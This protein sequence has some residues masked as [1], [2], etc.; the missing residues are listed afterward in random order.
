ML[1]GE[2]FAMKCLVDRDEQ[3]STTRRIESRQHCT[4]KDITASKFSQTFVNRLDPHKLALT[5]NK[6]GCGQL[7]LIDALLRDDRIAQSPT[8]IARRTRCSIGT[9]HE[10]IN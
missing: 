2:L 5:F 3:S 8:H 6:S 10:V 4:K 9:P 1:K 7:C